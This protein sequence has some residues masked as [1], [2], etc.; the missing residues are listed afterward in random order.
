MQA[1]TRSSIGSTTVRA[2]RRFSTAERSR[3]RLLSRGSMSFRSAY[4]DD[5]RRMARA[6]ARSGWTSSSLARTT[7]GNAH[8]QWSPQRETCR[9][10]PTVMHLSAI[11]DTG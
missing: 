8:K 7:D 10:T 3:G 11:A 2:A 5:R 6:S 1:V 9:R 4:R